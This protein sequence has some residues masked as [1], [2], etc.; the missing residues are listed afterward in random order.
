MTDPDFIPLSVNDVVQIDPMHDD[1]F[2][3]CFMVV[4]DPK[5]W[6]AQGY[7][8][9]PGKGLAF[10][11]CP[12]RGLVHIGVA[13]WATPRDDATAAPPEGGPDAR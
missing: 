12:T 5:P 6:G 9:V 2:G 4:T 8:S 11:R 7:V 3:G 13:E 1:V 10:Y